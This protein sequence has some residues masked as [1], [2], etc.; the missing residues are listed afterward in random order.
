MWEKRFSNYAGRWRGWKSQRQFQ[1]TMSQPLV[2]CGAQPGNKC[3]LEG[4][5]WEIRS[6]LLLFEKIQDSLGP[7]LASVTP[8]PSSA[9]CT[10]DTLHWV[11]PGGNGKKKYHA[12][13]PATCA[14]ISYLFPTGLWADFLNTGSNHLSSIAILPN[15]FFFSSLSAVSFLQYLCQSLL[16]LVVD[17][18]LITLFPAIVSSWS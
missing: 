1:P 11:A 8:S 12:P 7:L 18:A 14:G 10:K 3:L 6:S 16:F 17:W 15:W 4:K 13:N 9:L 5:S 2:S